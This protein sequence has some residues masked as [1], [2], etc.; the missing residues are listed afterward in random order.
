MTNEQ[1]WL[2]EQMYNEGYRDIKIEGVYAFFV[3]PTFIENSGN[4]KIRDHTP[5]IPCKVLG[6]NPNTRKYS[7]ADL[8]GIVDWEKVPIDTRIVVKT[9]VM[10]LK[11]YFAGYRPGKVRYYSAG[12]TSWSSNCGEFGIEEIDCD[13]VDLAERLTVFPY[14]CD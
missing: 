7:I 11:R 13:K 14:E 9:K 3:N 8:L 10:K 6:L 2:L 4:F 12:L 5:R 1:K